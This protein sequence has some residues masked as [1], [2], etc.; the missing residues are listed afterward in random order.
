[1]YAEAFA[2][3]GALDQLEGFASQH[4]PDFYRLPRNAATITLIEQPWT[5]PPLQAFLDDEP[6]IP[7]RAGEAIAWRLQE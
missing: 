6:L 2:A 5:V 3:A 7:L 1:L 4:G